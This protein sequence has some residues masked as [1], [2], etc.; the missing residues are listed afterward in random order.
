[1]N[2]VG[3]LYACSL[4]EEEAL[5]AFLIWHGTLKIRSATPIRE[6][7]FARHIDRPVQFNWYNNLSHSPRETAEGSLLF[8][9]S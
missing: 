9:S 3:D 5:P 7:R 2:G 8:S 1:M 6:S 4:A